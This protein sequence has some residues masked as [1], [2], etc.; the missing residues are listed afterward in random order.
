MAATLVQ[1]KTG[2]NGS[3]NPLTIT[4]DSATA[5]GNMIEVSA[6]GRVSS[7]TTGSISV[8]DNK[9]NTFGQVVIA[10]TGSLETSIAKFY[11]YN[12]SGGASHQVT[13]TWTNFGS[14]VFGLVAEWSGLTTADPLDRFTATAN[15]FASSITSSTTGTLAQAD[16][17]V[18]CAAYA[19]TG[20][21]TWTLGGGYTNVVQSA[22]LADEHKTVAGTAGV[23][24]SWTYS[25]TRTLGIALA[26]YKIAAAGGILYPQLERRI[27]GLNRGL[28]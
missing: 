9:G 17:L 14:S 11:A 13:I 4:F 16:E 21:G 2:G 5:G 26:T 24:G 3:T 22:A 15:Q 7:G 10:G 8:A 28:A 25:A 23:N 18:T 12:I 1:S 27:R 20:D 19:R 6:T